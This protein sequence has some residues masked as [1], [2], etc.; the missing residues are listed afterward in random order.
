M[1]D[2]RIDARA[3]AITRERFYRKGLM[4]VT[5]PCISSW[6]PAV[7]P[8]LAMASERSGG[9]DTPETYLRM[10]RDRDAQMWVY[11][12]SRETVQAVLITRILQYD[13]G[14][15]LCGVAVA[16]YNIKD[17]IDCLG[18]I[19]RWGV[20]NGCV[21]AEWVVRPGIE[22]LLKPRGYVKSHVLLE[23]AI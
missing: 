2:A 10:C 3:A 17:W 1:S 4:G 16:G 19:E 18:D 6:E 20:E 23:R 5:S 15:S 7:T 9:R 21:R 11:L 13:G 14:K 12:A 22:K 8:L